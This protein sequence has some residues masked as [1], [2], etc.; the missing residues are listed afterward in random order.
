M[1]H[2]PLLR[3]ERAG[4]FLH[5]SGHIFILL[6]PLLLRKEATVILTPEGL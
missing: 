6:L 1:F 2:E 5:W 4:L 3:D